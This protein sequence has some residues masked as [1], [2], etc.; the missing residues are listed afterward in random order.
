[1]RVLLGWNIFPLWPPVDC[2]DCDYFFKSHFSVILRNWFKNAN[3]SF[4]T[5]VKHFF[6]SMDASIE[7]QAK[8][9]SITS[10]PRINEEY[11]TQVSEEIEG[12][13]TK[14]LSQEFNSPAFLSLF[15]N[16]TDFSGTRR[17]GRSP[18][19]FRNIPEHWIRKSGTNRGSFPEWSPS[20]R[21]VLWLSVQRF[22]WLRP[23]GGLSQF[24]FVLSINTTCYNHVKE[25]HEKND[26]FLTSISDFRTTSTEMRGNCKSH[27]QLLF[28]PC[29]A[30]PDKP[31][32]WF[33][34]FDELKYSLCWK[35]YITQWKA[36][37]SCYMCYFS[38]LPQ[39]LFWKSFRLFELF[40]SETMTISFDFHTR[41]QN[42]FPIIHQSLK[43]GLNFYFVLC[44][45][46]FVSCINLYYS[47]FFCVL[48]SCH[49][50]VILV[51]S[52]EKVFRLLPNKES[53]LKTVIQNWR[54][55]YLTIGILQGI[56]T[57][58]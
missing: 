20:W 11:F 52:T 35:H 34:N 23:R 58:S 16:W 17:Y 44:F 5:T 14:E 33:P 51:F 22:S 46:L 30:V 50:P 54:K 36:T 12:R 29:S 43:I 42:F 57:V 53:W 47:Q 24:L 18:E 7:Q 56:S 28:L 38:T 8:V 4:F 6:P 39:H 32:K 55:F 45:V 15:L 37:F 21:G 3:N 40:L 48:N 31:F 19:P 9:G 26:Q 25:W 13:V 1:M 10:V 27:C 2:T 41:I 49:F